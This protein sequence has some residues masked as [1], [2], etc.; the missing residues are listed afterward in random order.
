MA[1]EEFEKQPNNERQRGITQMRTIS[2]YGMGVF[3]LIVGLVFM[4][5]NKYTIDFI[6]KYDD[7]LIKMFAVICCIYGAFRLYRG[8][9]KNYFND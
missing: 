9:H 6:S 3:F 5:P 4:F 2:N 8:Y 1:L 7:A